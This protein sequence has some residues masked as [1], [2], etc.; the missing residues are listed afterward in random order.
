[1]IL[2]KACHSYH[3]AVRQVVE[4]LAW[5]GEVVILGRAISK[6]YAARQQNH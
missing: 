5:G 4:E 1:V 3:K 2:V 6:G